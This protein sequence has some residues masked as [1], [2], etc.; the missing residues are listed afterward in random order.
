M[1]PPEEE[2]YRLPSADSVTDQHLASLL[3]FNERLNSLLG[4]IS[5]PATPTDTTPNL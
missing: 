1:T 2:K 3:G 4:V 5:P